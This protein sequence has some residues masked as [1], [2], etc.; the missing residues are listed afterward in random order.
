MK[1]IKGKGKLVSDNAAQVKKK[2]ANLRAPKKNSIEKP[3]NNNTPQLKQDKNKI[4]VYTIKRKDETTLIKRTYLVDLSVAIPY[5]VISDE[6]FDDEWY[7]D[8]G[9]SRHMTGRREEL[10]ESRSLKDGGCVKYGNNSYGMIKG[11]GMITN[12]EF[13]ICKVA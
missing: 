11:Y 8:S 2:L 12:G 13:S 7:I 1:D 9:C 10:R 5:F 3:T 6:Q 4:K